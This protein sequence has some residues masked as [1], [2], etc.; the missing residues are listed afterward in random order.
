M[1]MT[2]DQTFIATLIL[3]GA[4]IVLPA[5]VAGAVLYLYPKSKDQKPLAGFRLVQVISLTV[6]APLVPL[7]ALNDIIGDQAVTTILGVLTGYVFSLRSETT[8]KT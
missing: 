8:Q 5:V 7:M 2:D 3:L 1:L 4:M 6:L